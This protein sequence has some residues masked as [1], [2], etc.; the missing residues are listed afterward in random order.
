MSALLVH[1]LMRPE[2][3]KQARFLLNEIAENI[4]T[5]IAAHWQD[6]WHS[7]LL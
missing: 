6:Q 4:S 3:E 7:L 5:E 2:I 1:V